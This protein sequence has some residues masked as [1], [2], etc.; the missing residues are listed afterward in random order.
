MV[1]LIGVIVFFVGVALGYAGC[2]FATWTRVHQQE[3]AV[4]A[5]ITDINVL[6]DMKDEVPVDWVLMELETIVRKEY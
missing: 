1:Y 4:R 6:S 2:L 3:S 5:L